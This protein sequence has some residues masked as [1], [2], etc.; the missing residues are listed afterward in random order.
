MWIAIIFQ[1]IRHFFK[2]D[3]VNGADPLRFILDL[4]ENCV[5][6]FSERPKGFLIQKLG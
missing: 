5:K 1:G 3:S 6:K 2:R 4:G